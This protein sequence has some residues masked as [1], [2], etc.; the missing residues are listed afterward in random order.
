MENDTRS[1]RIVATCEGS[2][3]HIQQTKVGII[4]GLERARE[5]AAL[6]DGTSQFLMNLGPESMLGRCQFCGARFKCEVV[7]A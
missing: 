3:H 1:F 7:E 4:M 5:F 6:L 2:E